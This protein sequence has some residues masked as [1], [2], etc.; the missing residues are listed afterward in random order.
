MNHK[1]QRKNSRIVLNQYS[2][3]S[4]S[5]GKIFCLGKTANISLQGMS[6]LCSRE[7]KKYKQYKLLFYIVCNHR[8]VHVSVT[9]KIK[10]TYIEQNGIVAGFKFEEKNGFDEIKG[11]IN[12]M[13][14][15]NGAVA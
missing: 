14:I 9:S 5:S 2:I 3:V 7:P 6:I 4:Y 1:C 10:Y 11:W 15:P 8:I 13:L 12:R